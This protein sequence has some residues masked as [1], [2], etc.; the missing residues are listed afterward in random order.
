[1]IRNKTLLN[2]YLAI[3]EVEKSAPSLELLKRIVKA[4]LIKVPFENVSKLLFKQNDIN[5]IPDLASYLDGIEK[6]NFGG[7]CYANNY[8]LYLLLQH[9]GFEIIL[10]G[11][12][13]RN[14]DVHLLNII[15]ID[16]HEYIVDG[17]Y[18]A[19]FLVPLPTDLKTDFII[20]LGSEKYIIKPKDGSGRTKVEQY[21]NDKLQHW[22]TANPNPRRIEDFRR[23]IADSYSYEAI[24]M[25]AIRI[26]RFS[27]TGAY[28][29]KNFSFTE[30]NGSEIINQNLTRGE[31]PDFVE[32]KFG[33]PTKLVKKALE[34]IKELKDIYD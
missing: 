23:V 18:A 22:Y 21:Y 7:T 16:K 8:F 31:L 17:G 26:S 25:N 32:E 11:A 6:Y 5:Y 12:D 24:F 34:G 13:M 28:I 15:R 2:K 29:L 14:P 20:T 33:I 4:H 27:E 30:I 19:P 3:L 1:M 9:I 10:C